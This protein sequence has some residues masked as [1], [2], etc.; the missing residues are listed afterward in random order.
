MADDLTSAIF[1]GDGERDPLRSV[2]NQQRR[3]LPKRFYKAASIGA[4]A[5]FAAL[6]DGKSVR[7]PAGCA[8]ALPSE[9]AAALVAAEWN[10]QG[11]T[12]DPSTMPVTRL[13]NSALDGVARDIGAVAADMVKYLGSDLVCY[14]AGEPEALAAAQ[15]ATWNP[16]LD[17]ARSAFGARFI[18]AEGVMFVEQP[19]HAVAAAARA[20]EAHANADDAAFRIAALHSMTTLTGSALIAL[21]H[22]GGLLSLEQAWVAA[23]VDEYFQ[24]RLW[25]L[26]SEALARRTRR[27]EDMKAASELFAAL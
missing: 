14:R 8:L 13:A 9:R 4:E 2:Q 12:I 25:G 23:H 22:V 24:M 7:T 16:V 19:V 17:F 10:A 26:D 11:E 20:V 15:A 27:F 3:V 5:P 21:A 18:L 1:I 6:L